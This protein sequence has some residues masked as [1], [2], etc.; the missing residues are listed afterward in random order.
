MSRGRWHGRHQETN[1]ARCNGTYAPCR[2]KGN[3]CECLAYPARNRQRPAGVFPA[4]AE[5]TD[6]RSFEHFA[7]VV[8]RGRV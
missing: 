3:G 5:S 1:L 7:R 6:D 8:Q 4:D 2:R